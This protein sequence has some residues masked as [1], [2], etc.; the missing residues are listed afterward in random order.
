[1]AEPATVASCGRMKFCPE[2]KISACE[3]DLLDSASCMMGTL[4]ALKLSTNGGVM[5]GGRILENGLRG[6]GRFAPAPR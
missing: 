3:S 6:G 5:P 4:E 2:S 1:M